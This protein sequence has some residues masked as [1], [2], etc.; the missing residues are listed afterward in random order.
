M[1][2]RPSVQ[3]TQQIGRLSKCGHEVFDSLPFGSRSSSSSSELC[4]PN[5]ERKSVSAASGKELE[6]VLDTMDTG[7]ELRDV[8]TELGS[9]GKLCLG[10]CAF[11]CEFDDVVMR[12]VFAAVAGA[13]L[14]RS[15]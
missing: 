12:A 9:D 4:A 15:W 2:K 1:L 6:P 3:K 11:P 8:A 13:L 5:L 14:G 7:L 10:L